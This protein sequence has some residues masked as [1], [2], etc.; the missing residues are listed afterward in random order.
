MKR[1]TS[2]KQRII[3]ASTSEQENYLLKRKIDPVLT[4]LG[5]IQFMSVGPKGLPSTVESNVTIV[6]LNVPTFTFSCRT[7][8]QDTRQA[9]YRGPILVVSK[10]DN[11][12]SI[13]DIKSLDGVVLLEKPYE[14][15]DLQG[16][17]RKFILANNV[18]QRIHRR[19]NIVQPAEVEIVAKKTKTVSTVFNL[20]R[21]G[22][23]FEFPRKADVK[24]GDFLNMTIE[25]S[26]MNRIYAMPAKV[27]WTQP[28]GQA[29]GFGVGVEF[30]GRGN[31]H[32]QQIGL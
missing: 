5:P 18:A 22:C 20:S 31:G 7:T 10:V 26:E 2:N 13:K 6:L 30:I 9:G 14:V 11:P 28:R 15:K 4:D 24:T 16:I 17:V 12:E 27:V 21:G 25:L 29:G 3:L 1:N 23:Y 32:S 8:I 19:Y